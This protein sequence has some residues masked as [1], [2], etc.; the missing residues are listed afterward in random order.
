[1]FVN[2]AFVETYDPTIEDRYNRVIVVDNE[3]IMLTVFDTAGQDDFRLVRDQYLHAGEAFVCMYS[4][5]NQDSFDNVKQLRDQLIEITSEEDHP[6]ILVGNK[7]DLYEDR[8]VSVED[9]WNLAQEFKWGF[10]ETSA[11][12]KSNVFESYERLVTIVNNKKLEKMQDAALLTP[13]TAKKWR[14]QN[15]LSNNCLLL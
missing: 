8:A 7:S 14:R 2:S 1:M 3:S 11:K 4:I 15:R 12:T 13:R 5:T 10:I 6:V 9:G